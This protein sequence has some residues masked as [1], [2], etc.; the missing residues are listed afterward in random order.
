MPS[1][2]PDEPAGNERMA[3]STS[4]SPTLKAESKGISGGNDASFCSARC[5]SWSLTNIS[6]EK[7]ATTSSEI[8]TA[9]VMFL[10]S[11]LAESAASLEEEVGSRRG[12]G[13]DEWKSAS[14]SSRMALVHFIIDEARF[15][16]L[17]PLL[18]VRSM[19][20]PKFKR[21]YYAAVSAGLLTCSPDGVHMRHGQVWECVWW[22]R[23]QK[24]GVMIQIVEQYQAES[25]MA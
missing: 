4:S 9:A 1:G 11:N 21:R 10:S 3:R 17:P 12:W 20:C 25:H 14:S 15:L 6:V 2:P 16:F 7:S 13:K 24:E 19:S 5:L 23:C 22:L 8:L 18:G